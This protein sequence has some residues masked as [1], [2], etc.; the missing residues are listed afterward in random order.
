M[1]S[2]VSSDPRRESSPMMK[3][4][5]YSH[6]RFISS[7]SIEHS[8]WIS[9]S[10]ALSASSTSFKPSL[11]ESLRVG[12]RREVL[13]HGFLRLRGLR[14]RL[15]R[16][17]EETSARPKDELAEDLVD[18]G[19][20]LANERDDR[21]LDGLETAH[22]VMGFKDTRCKE[23]AGSKDRDGAAGGSGRVASAA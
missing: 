10:S 16:V 6:R 9:G 4:Q 13:G 12:W 11:W 5:G 17:C 22:D 1:D 3:I 2:S 23:T 14:V 8:P 7:A 21:L 20:D 19:F 15:R 18:L